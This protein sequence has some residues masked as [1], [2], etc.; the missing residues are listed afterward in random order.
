MDNPNLR[1]SG[2]FF[3]TQK[4]KGK[5]KRLAKAQNQNQRVPAWVIVK[6]QRNVMTH[7]KRRHWRRS[8][9]DV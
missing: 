7:P 9:L 3:M 8:T 1:L 4:T 2:E 6:T 5:K